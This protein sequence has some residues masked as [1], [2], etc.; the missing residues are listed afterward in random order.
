MPNSLLSHFPLLSLRAGRDGLW[1]TGLDPRHG[2]RLHRRRLMLHRAQGPPRGGPHTA[3]RDCVPRAGRAATPRMS[4]IPPPS[5]ARSDTRG[6]DGS[7]FVR[8]LCPLSGSCGR[9][10]ARECTLLGRVRRY[11]RSVSCRGC[12]GCGSVVRHARR[13]SRRDEGGGMRVR[14]TRLKPLKSRKIASPQPCFNIGWVTM[15]GA[16]ASGFSH[17]R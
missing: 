3:G 13:R 1:I 5:D 12:G 6:S 2:D 9:S 8:M 14:V 11:A 7:D 17:V 10:E 16:G 15:P 4:P